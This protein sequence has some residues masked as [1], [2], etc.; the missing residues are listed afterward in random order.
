MNEPRIAI[1]SCGSFREDLD[2]LKAQ[3]LLEDI[4]G[5]QNIIPG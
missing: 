4:E 2:T 5:N 3:G 1:V